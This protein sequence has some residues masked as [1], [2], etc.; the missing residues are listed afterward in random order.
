MSTAELAVSTAGPA[1]VFAALGDPTRLMLVGRL[2]GGD[3]QSI[4]TLSQGAAISRQAMTKHLQVLEAAG[5]VTRR[6]VGRESRYLLQPETL[7]KA[8]SYL[9]EV[10]AH[11]ERALERLQCFVDP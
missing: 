2:R 9:D 6:R 5:L 1:P 3:A 10:S 7:T 8:R 4:A 11:W